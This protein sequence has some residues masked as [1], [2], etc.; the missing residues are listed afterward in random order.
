M[1][2]RYKAHVRWA[3]LLL[4]TLTLSLF[5][6]ACGNSGST[7]GT[8]STPTPTLT[9]P[10]G[11]TYSGNGYTVSYP[12]GWTINTS[13]S[14]PVFSSASDPTAT[15]AIAVTSSPPIGG[16]NL[17]STLF[18]AAQTN[19]Q[20]KSGYQ[21]V[22][23]DLPST[24]IGGDTWQ[25]TAGTYGEN[26]IQVKGVVLGDQHPSTGGSIY[27]I[28]LTARTDAYDQLYSSGFQPILQSFKFTS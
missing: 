28:T 2:L 18:A 25:E 19:L 26:G 1:N 17:L 8:E 24:S 27:I 13:A 9:P 14:N 23:T 10:P 11:T 3:L 20:S 22:T 15:L 21:Q 5:L 16:S 7:T 12:Q 4:C 6:A